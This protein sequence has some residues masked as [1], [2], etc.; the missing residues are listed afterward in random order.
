MK[1]VDLSANEK[2]GYITVDA[3]KLFSLPPVVGKRVLQALILHVGGARVQI[4]SRSLTRIYSRLLRN[5]TQAQ[6]IARSILYSPPKR[7][8]VLVIGRSLPG[9]NECPPL[10]VSV[11]E[12]VHWDGRWRIT[13]KRLKGQYMGK[14]ELY[15]RHMR[16]ADADVA[17]RGVRKVH[18]S[19]LPDPLIRGGLPVVINKDGYIVLAPHFKVIDRSYG[20]DCDLKFEPLLPLIQHSELLA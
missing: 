20:V 18:V 3:N 17:R 1:E 12:T 5:R 15:I 11:G 8:N 10:P 16:Y 9:R 7:K 19:R 14:E 13:I 6:Q 2:Y 4:H